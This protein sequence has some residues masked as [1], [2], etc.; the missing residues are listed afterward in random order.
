MKNRMTKMS[1]TSIL[2][3]ALLA[4]VLLGTIF[5]GGLWWTVRRSV[6]SKS[7]NVWLIGS[8]PFRA[9]IAISGFYLVSRGD[10]RSLL[11]CLLGF[12]I[13]RIG[14]T[15]LLRAPHEQKSRSVRGTGS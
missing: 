5:Y 8:F 2:I 4:G 7:L 14:V 12:L 1:E 11:V 9:I 3:G 6:L 13:A 10:W 15:R